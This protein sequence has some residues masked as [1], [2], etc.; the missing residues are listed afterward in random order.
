MLIVAALLQVLIVVLI[1]LQQ[2]GKDLLG[3]HIG[4]G[5]T[6]RFRAK[7]FAQLQRLSLA[8]HDRRSSADSMY[9]IQYDASAIKDYLVSGILPTLAAA[10]SLGSMVYVTARLD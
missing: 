7:L 4:E 6:L 3:A 8:F 10:V 1:N 5:L 2:V 9:R